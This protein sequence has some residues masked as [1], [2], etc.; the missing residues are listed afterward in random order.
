LKNR[1]GRTTGA[2]GPNDLPGRARRVLSV[3]QRYSHRGGGRREGEGR[4]RGGEERGKAG[5]LRASKTLALL[6][7]RAAARRRF[8]TPDC[9][10][11]KEDVNFCGESRFKRSSEIAT[12]CLS[13]RVLSKANLNGQ[14]AFI[15]EDLEVLVSFKTEY[16]LFVACRFFPR[17]T[18]HATRK[19]NRCCSE[20]V[21]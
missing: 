17:I 19:K 16:R 8:I 6:R 14:K 12:E 9:R 7:G 4:G 13:H 21:R 15:R 2:K 11:T 5:M 18:L 10:W 3:S 1:K 20:D